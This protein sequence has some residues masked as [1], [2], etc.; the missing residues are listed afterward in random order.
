MEGW[1]VPAVPVVAPAV[2]PGLF[3]AAPVRQG[4]QPLGTRCA[5]AGYQRRLATWSC[6][7]SFSDWA[8][9]NSTDRV[10]ATT[11]GASH[12]VR[13]GGPLFS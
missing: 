11:D 4:F 6:S 5:D 10:L 2:V 8:G 3:L 9:I 7:S 12:R 1:P 13:V